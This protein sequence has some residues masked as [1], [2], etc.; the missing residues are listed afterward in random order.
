MISTRPFKLERAWTDKYKTYQTRKSKECK[1]RTYQI[2]KSQEWYV[3]DLSNRK[4]PGM[5]STRLIKSERA[6]ND[7]YVTY[8]PERASSDKYKTYQTGKRQEW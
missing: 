6:R 3:R 5:I 1:Y 2:G 4:E 7:K 8:K